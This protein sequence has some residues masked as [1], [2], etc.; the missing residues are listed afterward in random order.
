MFVNMKH[1]YKGLSGFKTQHASES[2]DFRAFLSSEPFLTFYNFHRQIDAFFGEQLR[3][4]EEKIPLAIRSVFESMIQTP[5]G[6]HFEGSK[7]VVK[8]RKNKPRGFPNR[9]IVNM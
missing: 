1:R 3:M 8:L 6:G 4:L 2:S 7:I 9:E 5:R